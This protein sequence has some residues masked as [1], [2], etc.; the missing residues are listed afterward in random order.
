MP[1]NG[2]PFAFQAS[3]SLSNLSVRTITTTASMNVS[4]QIVYA[5]TAGGDYTFTLVNPATL[6]TG[7]MLYVIKTTSDFNILTISSI[8]TTLNTIGES[9]LLVV[10][11]S[12]AWT[13]VER[14]I[15]STWTAYTPTGTFTNVTYTGFW[16]RVGDAIMGRVY[17]DFTNAPGAATLT[18]S[19]PSGLTIDTAKLTSTDGSDGIVGTVLLTETGTAKY[20]GGVVYSSTTVVQ[21]RYFNN[22]SPVQILGI[23]ATAPVTWDATDF[24][25]ICYEVPIAGWNG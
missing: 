18:V 10:N 25:S 6:P 13:I 7:T 19:I 9:V 23:T 15:P 16:K 14:R 11:G 3:Q 22:T 4:D 24:I 5:S 8:S 1:S 12:G 17:L 21:P 2:S 20:T